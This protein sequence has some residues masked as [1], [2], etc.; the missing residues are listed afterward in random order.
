[1]IYTHFKTVSID[2]KD[3]G[4]NTIIFIDEDGKHFHSALVSKLLSDSTIKKIE[5]L[6]SDEINHKPM[7]E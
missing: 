1:M 6:I 2:D 4:F 5:T 3:D 7:A